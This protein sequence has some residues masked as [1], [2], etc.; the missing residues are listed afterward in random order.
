MTTRGRNLE[1]E[2]NLNLL[3]F[4]FF[5]GWGGS[6]FVPEYDNDKKS[7]RRNVPGREG[8]GTARSSGPMWMELQWK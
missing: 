8:L 1:A 7:Q 3:R 5:F 6:F 2:Y 4:L